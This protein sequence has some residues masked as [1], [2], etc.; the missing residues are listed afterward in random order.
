MC[1][2]EIVVTIRQILWEHYTW[3]I[4]NSKEN[5]P[6]REIQTGE[7]LVSKLD[8]ACVDTFCD[9]LADLVGVA[10]CN[11]KCAGYEL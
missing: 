4:V 10:A 8:A 9:V 5:K 6:N 2:A 1:F 7:M 3:A 11:P